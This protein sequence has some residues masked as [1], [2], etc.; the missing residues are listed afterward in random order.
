[1]HS[2][3]EEIRGVKTFP[4]EVQ[5]NPIVSPRQE[6]PRPRLRPLQ[7]GQKKVVE[8]SDMPHGWKKKGIVVRPSG[9]K[10]Q[11]ERSNE[12]QFEQ[13]MARKA[14]LR[15]IEELRNGIPVATYGD[16]PYRTPEYAAKFC[17]Q[18]GLVPGSSISYRR[19]NNENR[20]LE[21]ITELAGIKK[22]KEK[23][24]KMQLDSDLSLVKSLS[25]SLVAC[26]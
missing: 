26:Y 13:V 24:K 8:T 10:A 11:C 17:Y 22:Y 20:N 14:R 12:Y 1:M 18:E 6:K 21:P 19:N 3:D 9:V 2:G 5:H 25:V 7:E 23:I 15:T 16:K 4:K